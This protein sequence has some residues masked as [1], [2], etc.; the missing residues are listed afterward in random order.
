MPRIGPMELIIVLVIVLLIF[1]V[2]KLPQIGK[3]LGEG[4]KS[5]KKGVSGEEEEE[6]KP[7]VAVEEPKA[8]ASETD[9]PVKASEEDLAAFKKWQAE[10]AKAAVVPTKEELNPKPKSK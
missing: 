1:G 7:E 6:K 5:F 3:S 10:Q 4:L 2:G 8:E 9:A